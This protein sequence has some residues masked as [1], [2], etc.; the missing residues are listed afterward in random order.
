MFRRQ[1]HAAASALDVQVL[2]L[3]VEERKWQLIWAGAP[4]DEVLT[5]AIGIDVAEILGAVPHSFD[6]GLCR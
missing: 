1:H 6:E 4:I 3:L 2:T 5:S